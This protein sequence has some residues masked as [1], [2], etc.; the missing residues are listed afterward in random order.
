[1][2]VGNIINK[3]GALKKKLEN[4]TQWYNYIEQVLGLITI[5]STVNIGIGPQ[6]Q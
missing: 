5:N 6:I 2:F 3:I 4:K 1:M